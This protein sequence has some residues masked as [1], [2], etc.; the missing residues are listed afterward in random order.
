MAMPGEQQVPRALE[1]VRVLDL[2]RLLPG[3]IATL[4]L[5]DLGASVDKVEDPHGGDYA[6]ISGPP[7]GGQSAL[8]HALNR[9]KRSLVLD[10]KQPAGADALRRMVTR[11]DVLFEQFRPGVLDRL[12]LS[13]A[14]LR[15]LNPRL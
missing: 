14:S 12:G 15:E 3:P 13:H 11:Y 5:A 4:V 10:L 6:R 7:V 1:G 2:T 9:G 8:F